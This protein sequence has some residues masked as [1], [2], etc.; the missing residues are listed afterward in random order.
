MKQLKKMKQQSGFTMIELV[1][2]MVIVGTLAA[3]AV[4]KFADAA[5]DARITKLESLRNSVVSTTSVIH[6][7]TQSRGKPDITAC[8]SEAI[9]DATAIATNS[10]SDT[11]AGTFCTQGGV[12]TLTKGYPA[13]GV[14]PTSSAGATTV[15]NTGI[16]SVAGLTAASFRPTL[17]QINKAGF[18]VAASG[19]TIAFSVTGGPGT[20][21]SAGTEVNTTCAFTYAESTGS[22][23]EPVVTAPIVSGC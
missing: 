1:T 15:A 11:T 12:L 2:V 7:A 23:V 22:G 6:N 4:P 19:A 17:T 14:V 16:I 18:G 5:R 20:S 3:V 21:G 13:S 10:L 9:T 8:P